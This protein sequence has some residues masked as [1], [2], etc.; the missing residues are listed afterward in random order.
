MTKL[1]LETQGAQQ[2]ASRM[3][4]LRGS[5]GQDLNSMTTSVNQLTSDLWHGSS[6]NRFNTTYMDWQTRMN[7]LLLELDDHIK[8]LK[9]EIRHWIEEDS[10]EVGK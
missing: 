7:K 2:V 6:S 4:Q 10:D 3:T 8:D 1:L 9:D 5:M